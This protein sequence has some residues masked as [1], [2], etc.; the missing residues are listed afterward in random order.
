MCSANYILVPKEEVLQLSW[1]SPA[2]F[3]NIAADL[4]LQEL[5]EFQYDQ[6]NSIVLYTAGSDVVNAYWNVLSTLFDI[7]EDAEVSLYDGNTESQFVLVDMDDAALVPWH[8]RRIAERDLPLGVNYPYNYTGSCHRSGQTIHTYIV[9]TGIDIQH[10]QFEG[11]AQWGANFAD[12]IDSD[13]N[14]HGTHVAGLVGSKR[15]GV[16]VDARLYAVKVLNCQGSGTMS[17]VIKGIEWAFKSHVQNNKNNGPVKS[18]VNM[19]LGGPYSRAL[20]RAIEACV[21]KDGHFFMVVAAGNENQDACNVSPASVQ[22]IVT[23]MASDENDNKAWF[24]NCGE[25]GNVFAPGVDILS[26]I[27]GGQVATFSGTS[28]ASPIMAGAMNH[29]IDMYPNN[30]LKDMRALLKEVS[31]RDKVTGNAANTPNLLLHVQRD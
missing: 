27:A 14:N 29:Y 22:T 31:S 19:S 10:A 30:T 24:S 16:C 3:N 15:Y 1:A 23:V 11:R 17:G 25:C 8:L 7:E 26:T 9:D 13:C 20:N 2:T 12:K 21:R 18:V 5:A 4:R 6:S 28:M